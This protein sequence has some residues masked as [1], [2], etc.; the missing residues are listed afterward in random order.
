MRNDKSFS[1]AFEGGK[2]GVG[3]TGWEDPVIIHYLENQFGLGDSRVY[4]GEIGIVPG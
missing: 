3:R 1:T 4:F 2:H